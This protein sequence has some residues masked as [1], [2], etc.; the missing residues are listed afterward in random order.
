METE[1]RS[2]ISPQTADG[3]SWWKLIEQ[4]ALQS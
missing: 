1:T 4:L 2:L 3:P